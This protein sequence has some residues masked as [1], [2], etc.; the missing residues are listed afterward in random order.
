MPQFNRT[1]REILRTMR[2]FNRP[3]S[4]REISLKSN[5][6]WATVNKYIESFQQ[7]GIVKRVGANWTIN[8][9]ALSL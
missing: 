3:M 4:I 8:E 9:E 1:Q 5:V 7:K 6:S 2:Q